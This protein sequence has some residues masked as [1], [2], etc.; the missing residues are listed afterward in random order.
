MQH[1]LNA[2]AILTLLAAIQG[3][4]S[5]IMIAR[6]VQASILT[7]QLAVMPLMPLP[8]SADIIWI[9]QLAMIAQPSVLMK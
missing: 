4:I 7:G 6:L 9:L 2:R 5:T 1:T 8:V 3:I